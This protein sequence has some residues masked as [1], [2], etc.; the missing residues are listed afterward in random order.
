MGWPNHLSRK[1]AKKDSV[2]WRPTSIATAYDEALARLGKRNRLR[3]RGTETTL[4]ARAV[5][6]ALT[7]QLIEI[8][9]VVVKYHQTEIVTY[10]KDGTIVIRDGGWNTPSTRD[11]LSTY[12]PGLRAWS[13]KPDND[14]K[15]ESCMHVAIG[16]PWLEESKHRGRYALPLGDERGH[17]TIVVWPDGGI[18]YENETHLEVVARRVRVI[19]AA[20]NPPP[21]RPRRRRQFGALEGQQ[22]LNFNRSAA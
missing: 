2:D 3:L 15:L 10:R 17:E 18:G 4:V 5:F 7:N 16:S 20:K 14:R 22:S 19:E 8:E 9:A 1:D 11:K 13:Q 12:V 6:D 21:A